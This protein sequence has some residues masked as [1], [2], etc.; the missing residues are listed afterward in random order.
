MIRRKV[1]IFNSSNN[2]LISNSTLVSPVKTYNNSEV[3]KSQILN[4]NKNKSG[5]CPITNNLNAKRY[6]GSGI[7]LA[8][9]LRSY[10]N[11]KELN[12]NPRPIA[13]ALLKYGYLNFTL[14]I[15]E[16][17]SEDKLIEREQFY[18]NTLVPEY[19][20]L[21]YANSLLGYNHTKETIE[22]LKQRVISSEDKELL[23]L[24]H[25]GKVVSQEA[26]NKLASPTRNYKKDNPLTPEALANIKAKT[27]EGEGV[28]LSVLNNKTKELKEFTNQTE[29]GKFGGITRQAIHNA[30]KR[31]TLVNEI[32]HITKN[33]KK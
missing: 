17:C 33:K 22:K 2:N 16:Y 12:I 21:K 20:I 4:D 1:T 7:N 19:N 27:I 11:T 23:S 9:R 18:L 14:D 5:I 24:V 6:V 10:Y 26:K 25:K 15:L 13:E 30:I 8:K 3:L 31:G 28:S 32:Y 29:A